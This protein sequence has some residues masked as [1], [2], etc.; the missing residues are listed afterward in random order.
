MSF[1]AGFPQDG[2]PDKGWQLFVTSTVFVI[3]AAIFVAIRLAA[4]WT[5]HTIGAD[6]VTIFLSLVGSQVLLDTL[7][8]KQ[9]PNPTLLTRICVPQLFSIVLTIA[10]DNCTY[11]KRPT[12]FLRT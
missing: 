8:A 4:R 12:R 6:D 5:K 10:M 9:V 2:I 3:L 11:L 1:G 7:L